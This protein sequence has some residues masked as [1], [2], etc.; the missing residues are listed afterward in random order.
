[1]CSGFFPPSS[2]NALRHYNTCYFLKNYFGS[3]LGSGF[4]AMIIVSIL[5]VSSA[6]IAA[7]ITL[8]LAVTLVIKQ[9]V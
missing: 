4:Y 2:V 6:V 1:M 8:N 5:T 7:M 9:R 3:S